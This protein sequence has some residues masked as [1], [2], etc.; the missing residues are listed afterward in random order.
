MTVS[1]ILALL[2]RYALARGGHNFNRQDFLRYGAHH[3]LSRRTPCELIDDAFHEAQAERVIEKVPGF[4]A[5]V[6]P[7]WRARAQ[8][9]AA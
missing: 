3:G 1:E 8:R 7:L 6:H 2:V 5:E 9:A 4:E